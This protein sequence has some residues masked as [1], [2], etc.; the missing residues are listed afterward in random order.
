MG[1][2]LN[3]AAP[4]GDDSKKERKQNA[5]GT[6]QEEEAAPA[7][8]PKKEEQPSNMITTLK[9]DADDKDEA[10]TWGRAPE[11]KNAGPGAGVSY[12]AA[13]QMPGLVNAAR[14]PTLDKTTAS[15]AVKIGE[16]PVKA[17]CE[18]GTNKFA[19]L[20]LAR[21]DDDDD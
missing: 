20:Q 19:K 8:A 11:A 9:E 12:V 17:R 16:A 3:T 15:T 5:D 7:P 18:E 1:T 13:R 10:K 2:N 6:W 14:F 21:D 4:A